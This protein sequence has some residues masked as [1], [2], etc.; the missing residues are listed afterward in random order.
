MQG[1]HLASDEALHGIDLG[2]YDYFL[3]AS[4]VEAG[5][6]RLT[7]EFYECETRKKTSDVVSEIVAEADFQLGSP[8]VLS[9]GWDIYRGQNY[10]AAIARRRLAYSR[11]SC[12]SDPAAN[13]SDYRNCRDDVAIQ[14]PPALPPQCHAI[15]IPVHYLL[16]A[17]RATTEQ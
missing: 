10:W 14:R 2:K 13:N 16:S 1:I 17:C 5:V 9:A 6:G 7:I 11:Y 15:A 8:A 3:T 4:G 12:R